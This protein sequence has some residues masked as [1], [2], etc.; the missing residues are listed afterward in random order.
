[1]VRQFLL[2][3]DGEKNVTKK[4]ASGKKRLGCAILVL[5]ILVGV[6]GGGAFLW[7]QRSNSERLRQKGLLAARTGQH[8]K[9]I[10]LLKRAKELDP[11]SEEIREALVEAYTRYKQFD[12]AFAE[13]DEAVA[14]GYAKPEA[15]MLK[16]R[17]LI[18]RGKYRMAAG[19]KEVN[20]KL[21]DDIIAHE[22]NPAM[23]L[24]A[25][26]VPNLENQAKGHNFVAGLNFDTG[27]MLT[28]KQIFLLRDAETARLAGR[29]DEAKAKS[30]EVRAVRIDMLLVRRQ[31]ERASQKAI[32][33]DPKL[34]SSRLALAR[35]YLSDFVPNVEQARI[36]LEAAVAEAPDHSE[37]RYLMGTA[38]ML[39]E[40][41]EQALAEIRAIPRDDRNHD[42]IILEAR[43][44]AYLEWWPEIDELL[45]APYERNP[46]NIE[47]A[48]FRGT[49]L[50]RMGNLTEGL[51]LLQNIFAKPGRYWPEARLELAQ[52]LLQA[53][54]TEQAV[55]TFKTVI[56]DIDRTRP[57][58]AKAV[59]ELR[60]TKYE[61]CVSLA[62]QLKDDSPLDS[63]KY[64]REAVLL[65][66][67]RT[68]ALALARETFAKLEQGEK[69][70]KLLFVHIEALSIAKGI[71]AAL[72]VCAEELKKPDSPVKQLRRLRARLYGRKGAYR[73]A[74]EE[75]EQLCNDYPED[76]TLALELARLKVHLELHD[77]AMQIYD[78]LRKSHPSNTRVVAEKAFALLAAGEDEK[79]AALLEEYSKAPDAQAVRQW[80]IRIYSRLDR[81]DK[82]LALARL[83]ARHNPNDAQSHATLAMLLMREGIPVEATRAFSDALRIDPKNQTAHGLGLL[84]L[85]EGKNEKA[86]ELFK[87][88]VK[89][90]PDWPGGH[91]YLAMTLYAEGRGG[92]ATDVLK[93][94]VTSA[95]AGGAVWD[96][97][98]WLLAIMYA[99]EGNLEA[100]AGVNRTLRSSQYGLTHE[101]EALLQQLA[102]REEADRSQFAKHSSL[103]VAF[104]NGGFDNQAGVHW[105]QLAEMKLPSALPACWYGRTLIKVNKIAPAKAHYQNVLKAY[106]DSVRARLDLAEC[107][108]KSGETAAGM[109]TVE[110]VLG[111][112]SE[113]ENA[114]AT[115]HT[116]L[117]NGYEE[118]EQ[119]D[120][121]I[122]HYRETLKLQSG[123]VVALNDLAW[124]LATHKNDPK[125]ALP[126]AEQAVRR[127]GGVP[128]IMDTLGWIYYLNGEPS[129]ALNLLE[130][131]R[132]RLGTNP[133]VRYHLGMTYVRLGRGQDAKTELEECLALSDDFE[134]ADDARRALESL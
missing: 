99:G 66:P 108:K 14:N 80:L 49:A 101:R 11:D 126:L 28:A 15:A 27:R 94:L 20:A 102:K 122:F 129:K 37:V 51:N 53:K 83:D 25:D 33:L 36:H 38:E 120:K 31:A 104:G 22:I 29:E 134:H 132:A 13:L 125:A 95:R 23:R 19:G 97:P 81:I 130:L 119:Y 121:A 39:E 85:V 48:F 127:S 93:Q 133:T 35:L 9:A 100:A 47:L 5:I 96:G 77:E 63:V 16:A 55:A 26:N 61:V 75:F 78:R 116:W 10:Q 69:G 42:M 56:S 67:Q 111:L 6:A 65:F 105:K 76:A 71:D 98:R 8:E 40:N 92:E 74:M 24:C 62:R 109:K 110:H 7:H 117:G 44:L 1:M 41:Y 107:Q 52:G 54:N 128:E 50:M 84:Y 115:V 4:S 12:Q 89:A 79:A 46:D 59:Q 91:M 106:P 32:E 58:N 87:Q 60:E 45:R 113:S 18:G 34:V 112:V 88:A 68:E 72:N 90:I 57:H 118:L 131:A 43:N 124:L 86:R 2:G 103:L 114:R 123:N 3:T 30:A 82:V 17:V 70:D 73:K 21:I 64:A